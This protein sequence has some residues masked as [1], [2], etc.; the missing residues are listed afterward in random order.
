M[1]RTL[2]WPFPDGRFPPQLGA[3]VQR[4][5]LSGTSP[6]RLVQ[7]DRDG[8]WAVGDGD[9]PNNPDAVVATHMA[10]VLE[11]NSSVAELADLA[12]GW[13][14]IRQNP[15]EP[16]VRELLDEDDHR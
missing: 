14:A 5:V 4:T 13:I 6:A 10:H 2:Q 7:H 1:F 16:W 12:P 9:D 8:D 11:R 3:V 15:G